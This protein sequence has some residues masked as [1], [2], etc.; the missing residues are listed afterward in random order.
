M[1][2]LVLLATG[3]GPQ[4]GGINSF[5]YDLA[6]SLAVLLAGRVRITCVVPAATPDE[7]E[8]V[9]KDPSVELLPLTVG[10]TSGSLGPET[11]H[12]IAAELYRVEA[13]PLE[14][15]VRESIFTEALAGFA[16]RLKRSTAGVTPTD[17]SSPL[18]EDVPF[19]H[20]AALIALL[21]ER[22]ETAA[23]LGAQA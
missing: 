13:I 20:L 12:E 11:A 8:E 6:R 5:N 1:N 9:G 2:R 22:A 21:G 18:F 16:D 17:L 4:F 15:R 14:G 10:Q 3:W 7:L 23:G 19:I